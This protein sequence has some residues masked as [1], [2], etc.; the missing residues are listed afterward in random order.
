[1]PFI[2]S[3]AG[4]KKASVA[5]TV[6]IADRERIFR[7]KS[8]YADMIP[9]IFVFDIHLKMF[10]ERTRSPRRSTIAWTYSYICAA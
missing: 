10:G 3:A 4:H 9:K 2:S 6:I 8:G 7:N 5:K 1:M